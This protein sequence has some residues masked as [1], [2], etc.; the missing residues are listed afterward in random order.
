MSKSFEL[1]DCFGLMYLPT[2]QQHL[3]MTS[4]NF[5]RLSPSVSCVMTFF[6]LV[7]LF[8]FCPDADLLPLVPLKL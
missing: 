8:S 2:K 7:L 3:S 6:C 5:C 4:I 1:I